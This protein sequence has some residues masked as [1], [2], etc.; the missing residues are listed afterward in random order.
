MR[1]GEFA[2]AIE[3]LG[4]F[5]LLFPVAQADEFDHLFVLRIQGLE[6]GDV[7]VGRRDIALL[8]I[9]EREGDKAADGL[10]ADLF[11]EVLRVLVG[12][13]EF[14]HLGEERRSL[15]Q[16][17]PEVRFLGL[18]VELARLRLL[19]GIQVGGGRATGRLRRAASA[20]R[21]GLL[22]DRRDYQQ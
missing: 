13:I 14:Q 3:R 17:V 10:E 16:V 19:L 15:D 22:H 11:E 1:V 2:L 20:P 4:L 9:A 18:L 6:L 12:G 21:R 8:E 5:E 7:A